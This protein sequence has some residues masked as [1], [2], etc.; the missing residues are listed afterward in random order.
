MLVSDR[1]EVAGISGNSFP[2]TSFALVA[3][4]QD[5]IKRVD[6]LV[7][8]EDVDGLGRRPVLNEEEADTRH[9]VVMSDNLAGKSFAFYG[10]KSDEVEIDVDA[11]YD[12]A[13][14]VV[15]PLGQFVAYADDTES[16]AEHAKIDVEHDGMHV[17]EV[18]QYENYASV[19]S[20]SST[21]E[22][23]PLMDWDD[24]KRPVIGEAVSGNI[25]FINDIDPYRLFLKKDQEINI[26]VESV[27]FDPVVSVDMDAIWEDDG[28]LST[29]DDSGKGM[30]GMDAEMNYRAPA[31]G[32]YYVIVKSASGYETGGYYLTVDEAQTGDPTPMAP[33][34]T[35]TPIRSAQGNMTRYESEGTPTFRIDHPAD[36]YA[37]SP[38]SATAVL[39]KFVTYC[40]ATTDEQ[41]V[42][43]I[44]EERLADYN[45]GDITLEEYAALT[46]EV[47]KS[48]PGLSEVT[49]SEVVTNTHGV[50]LHVL[51]YELAAGRLRSVRIMTI[52]KGVGFNATMIM[53]AVPPGAD[54]S[55]GQSIE[56]LH[57]W[58][59]ATIEHMINSFLVQD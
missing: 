44:A 51:E 45:L 25:D 27:M 14:T 31:D 49:R 50:P 6:G 17:V 56:H 55:Y 9:M 58:M 59:D 35:P 30:F 12:Y 23:T 21:A 34:P 54:D 53:P 47:I 29:D 40:R 26:R 33:E 4:A 57:R 3:S 48:Q 13:F 37:V 10:V 42:L 46:E 41:V 36:W 7:N 5:V 52:H 43:L 39:C 16:G 2:D 1:G 38:S 24:H 11:V 19:G 8:G 15:D 32:I 20:I 18:Y 28:N 22:L